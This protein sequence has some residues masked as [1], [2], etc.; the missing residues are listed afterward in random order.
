MKT[1]TNFSLSLAEVSAFG[2]VQS[3]GSLALT[4][5]PA[6]SQARTLQSLLFC[7]T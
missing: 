6:P 2:L 7:P 5:S 4:S 1:L 3:A